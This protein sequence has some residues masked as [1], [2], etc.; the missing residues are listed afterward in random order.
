MILLDGEADLAEAVD[1]RFRGKAVEIP[2]D[3]VV[4]EDGKL[5]RGEV[6]PQEPV[7]RC[8]ARRML[9]D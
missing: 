7:V 4:V 3:A 8:G 9:C 6:H 1:E 2:Y 5:V